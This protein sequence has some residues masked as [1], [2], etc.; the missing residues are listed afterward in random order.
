MLNGKMNDT[1]VLALGAKL[2]VGDGVHV[3]LLPLTGA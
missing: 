1:N 2:E 3:D